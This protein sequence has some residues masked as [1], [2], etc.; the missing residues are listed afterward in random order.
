MKGCAA[1]R[2]F[3]PFAVV[4]EPPAGRCL[5]G[6]SAAAP[7][8]ICCLS[9][10]IKSLPPTLPPHCYKRTHVYLCTCEDPHLNACGAKH[11]NQTQTVTSRSPR[12]WKEELNLQTALWRSQE[13]KMVLTVKIQTSPRKDRRANTTHIHTHTHTHILLSES[14][15][16]KYTATYTHAHALLQNIH[17]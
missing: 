17:K 4:L 3:G 6:G 7:E 10:S 12:L 13:S 8:V 2:P 1:A 11:V 15:T 16:V 5:I 14:L 9:C